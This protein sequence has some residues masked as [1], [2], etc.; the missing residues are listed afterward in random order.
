M[1]AYT[2]FQQAIED[3]YHK[4]HKCDTDTFQVALCNNANPPS[5]SLD[6]VLADIV[7]IAYTNLSTQVITTT[8]S[9][10][11]TGNFSLVFDDLTLTASGTVAAFQYVVVF[12]QTSATPDDAL[13]GFFD[14]GSDLVL[15]NGESLTIDFGAD[16]PTTGEIFAA[17]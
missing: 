9:G 4:V 7:Q 10:Q 13:I 3:F 2:K 1:A 6:A 5:V 8:S 11:T 12:N 15:S 17:S 14:Y 16:G